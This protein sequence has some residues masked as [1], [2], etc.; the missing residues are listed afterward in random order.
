MADQNPTG[1][2]YLVPLDLPAKHIAILR[3]TLDHCL[4]GVRGDLSGWARMPNLHQAH[5][6][7]CAY[8]RL[9]RA[10]NCGRVSVPDEAAREAVACIAAEADRENNFAAVLAEHNAFQ[11]LLAKL[12][13]TEGKKP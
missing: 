1:G 12:S 7:A 5:R 9:L 3:R 6:E 4:E 13:A 11:G 2:G 10:L 8:D